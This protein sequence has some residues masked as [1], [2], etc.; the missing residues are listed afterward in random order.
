MQQNIPPPPPGFT[1]VGPGGS[2]PIPPPGFALVQPSPP[3]Q[4]QRPERAQTAPPVMSAPPAL[5][6][7]PFDPNDLRGAVVPGGP[8]DTPAKRGLTAP[9]A[10]GYQLP[11][12]VLDYE[13]LTP[14]DLG[15]LTRGTRVLLPP[16]QPGGSRQIVTLARDMNAPQRDAIMGE[17]R[18][19]FGGVQTYTPGIADT[20][21]AVTSGASEQVP[22]LDELQVAADALLSGQSFSQARDDYQLTQQAL[23]ESDRTA[24]N[25][26]G[27]LGFLGTMAL[28]GAAGVN[29]VRGLGLTGAARSAALA[30]GAAPVGF[31][32]G[33][34]GA[35][36][37]AADRFAPGVLSA[38]LTAGGTGIIDAGIRAAP[39]IASGLSEAGSVIS[40]GFG[41]EPR[42]A[43]IT[44]RA[45]EQA[46]RYVERLIQSSGADI[47]ANPIE[48]LGKPVTAAEAIGPSGVAN[49]TALSRRAGR[50]GNMANAQLGTRASEQ[51]N[52]VVQD[53]GDITGMDPAGSADAVANIVDTGRQRAAPLW[54]QVEELQV[55]PTPAMEDILRRPSGRAA[56][57]R[58]YRIARDEGVNPESLGLFVV[59]A[60]D[61]GLPT[62]ASSIARDP[63]TIADLDA[64]RAGTRTV[65]A[66]RGPSLL[67]FISR[68]GGLRDEGG[69]LQQIG[70]DVWNRQGAWRNR[71]VRDD[72]L[73]SEEM[74]QRALD[75]GYFDD[76]AN[77]VDPEN[78]QRLG[79]QDLINAID[80]ELRG[81]AR[82]ARTEGDTDRSAAAVLRRQRRAALDERLQRENIDINTASNDEILRRLRDADDA[83][84]RI[85]AQ[86]YGEGPDAPRI[87]LVPGA[88]PSVRTLDY[89]RRGLNQVLEGFRDKTTRR[90][91]L[92]EES[93]PILNNVTRFRDELIQATGGDQ[94][95]YAQALS[96]SGDYLRVENAFNQAERLFRLNTSQRAFDLAT[97]RMGP[98]ERNALVAG[99]ADRLFRDAQAGRLGPRQLNQISIP[100]IRGKLASLIGPNG[101][102][103][104]MQRVAAEIELSR[105]G[106]RMAPGTNSTT[107]EATEAMREQDRG[108]GIMN[109]LA[110]NI[111]QTRSVLGG[112]AM[113][114]GQ[115]LT[116]PIA[117]F[118]RGA[119]APAAQ[120]VRDE[121]AR[122]L[123]M[124]PG[125]LAALLAESGD[126]STREV[127][128]LAERLQR[129][130]D[131][132]TVADEFSIPQP[133]VRSAG[134][135]GRR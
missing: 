4:A 27:I 2:P 111:E 123:L 14:A 6:Q 103:Q 128:S 83:E 16:D 8:A 98:A 80:N 45:T 5:E 131:Q 93:K 63:E 33:F 20:V 36:G 19:T 121:I 31:A 55:T 100:L 48:A 11:E 67:E 40:R 69:E 106:A 41:I 124:P 94:G 104:F 3:P 117:G 119:T 12:G 68:N 74:A 92:N 23:N 130:S 76:L 9:L 112:T 66:G 110:R 99:Y 78:Y 102:D 88:V 122:L 56:L 26:G 77:Q 37:S 115:A 44:P 43:V 134:Q 29:S 32:Y 87:E 1:I 24:R 57:R 34:G 113:T 15:Q 75:A 91:D 135:G 105:S 28:P 38:A 51:P 89:V 64:L 120:P 71:V 107:A 65:G 97:S 53:F 7:D 22:G 109:D 90:L 70:A 132:P 86:L 118:I 126:L 59:E 30:G 42:E 58:A 46:Q 17:Q 116:A 108:V 54:A 49:M 85:F 21:A 125:E 47:T 73:T 62:G 39:N 129:A 10:S 84:A 81:N 72:G 25:A 95:P 127:R 82:F 52:R 60:G 50:A 96:V 18:Q 114:A 35:E 133:G 13:A 101:A 61:G 79:G